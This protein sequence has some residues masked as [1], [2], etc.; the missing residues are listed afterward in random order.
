MYFRKPQCKYVGACVDG[1]NHKHTHTKHVGL[2]YL[3]G[4]DVEGLLRLYEQSTH[5]LLIN[6]RSAFP[7]E[8]F[9]F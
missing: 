8:H 2:V 6:C 4:K 1:R 9:A 5:E 7:F 3:L